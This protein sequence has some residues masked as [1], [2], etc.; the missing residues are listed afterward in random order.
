MNSKNIFTA[1]LKIYM[2]LI[3]IMAMFPADSLAQEKQDEQKRRF[4]IS[5]YAFRNDSTKEVTEDGW[6]EWI[7]THGKAFFDMEK[8]E[9][10]I[11]TGYGKDEY[12]LYDGKNE[13][14][15]F[16]FKA[17]DEEG[18]EVRISFERKEDYS[19]CYIFYSDFALVFYVTY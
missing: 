15:N 2:P 8:S 6:S 18:D 13:K 16:H 11:I 1:G 12:Y 5:S 14:P 3:F 7:E 9:L 19:M 17:L 10:I 4:N